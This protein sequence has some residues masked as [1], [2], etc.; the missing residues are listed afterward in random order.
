MDLV[1]LVPSENTT[2]LFDPG[3]L[4]APPTGV[5]TTEPA[6]ALKDIRV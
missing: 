5:E 3:G 1:T 2:G 4:F 6:I